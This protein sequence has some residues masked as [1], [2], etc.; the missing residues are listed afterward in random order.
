M[1]RVSLILV[2]IR[3]GTG[4]SVCGHSNPEPSP[5]YN[6]R[7]RFLIVLAVRL[8]VLA[9]V[10]LVLTLYL[11]LNVLLLERAIRVVFKKHLIEL[12]VHLGLQQLGRF[13]GDTPLLDFARAACVSLLGSLGRGC[14]ILHLQ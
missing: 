14:I 2:L 3:G 8:L 6:L 10:L 11:T 5:N 13:V 1:T 9:H 7:P 12:V 4:R